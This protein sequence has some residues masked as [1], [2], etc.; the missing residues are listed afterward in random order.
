[1]SI[2]KT[3][4]ERR[5][6]PRVEGEIAPAELEIIFKCALTASDHKRLHPWRFVLCHPEHKQALKD[7]I[8][9]ARSP[10]SEEAHLASMERVERRLDFAPHI[11]SCLLLINRGSGVPEIKQVLSAGASI[12]NVIIAAKSLGYSCFW[13][14]GEWAYCTTLHERLGLNSNT[15]TTGFLGFGRQVAPRNCAKPGCRP[16][17]DA[18]FTSLDKWLGKGDLLPTESCLYL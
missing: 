13:I 6:Q 4:P 10:E 1:M 7:L 5:S 17:R 2:V 12:Q 11:V 9:A 14:T 16:L 8:L 3:I 18:H 15:I